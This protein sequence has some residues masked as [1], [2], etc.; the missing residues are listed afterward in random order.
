MRPSESATFSFIIKIWLE[1]HDEAGSHV[2]WRVH[3][4]HVPSGRR[5]YIRDIEE[6]RRFIVPYLEE[7][8]VEP[9]G[10]RRLRRRLLG[11]LRPRAGL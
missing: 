4:T 8:G 10:W 5:Q 3:I 11:L 1:A 7:A 9:G 6:I 2:E